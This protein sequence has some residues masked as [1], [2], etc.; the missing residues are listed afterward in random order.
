MTS[1]DEY[2]FVQIQSFFSNSSE[3]VILGE[4]GPG[5]FRFLGPA[6]GVVPISP[7]GIRD[8]GT[9]P[10]SMLSDALLS[11]NY[12]FDHQG[13]ISN[14]SC[15]Y[16]T[17]SPITFLAVPNDTFSVWVNASCNEVGLDDIGTNY[18]V[19]DTDR[20]LTLWACK[21]IPT[22]EQYPA[23]HIYLRGSGGVYEPEIGNITCTVSPIQ[24]AVFP[25]TYQSRTGI[26]STQKQI[27]AAAP[28]NSFSNLIEYAIWVFQDVLQQAQTVSVNLVAALVQDLG[29]QGGV[30]L[31]LQN[32]QYLRLYEAMIQGILVDEV[33]TASNSSP[34]LLM[35]VPQVTYMRFLY[36][37]MDP[38]ASCMRTM[39]GT[40]SAEVTGLVA[41]PVHIAFLI[42]MTILNLVSLIAV[43]I[44]IA[45]AKRGRHEFDPIDPRPLL[46]AEPSLNQGDDSGW[47]D[48]VLYRSR[49][50]RG[51]HI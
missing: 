18:T 24:P 28:A 26:F 39:N 10:P 13:L 43:L 6:R 11:Y 44:S 34:P 45:K 38:P 7:N 20:T 35:V 19:S 25:V 12:T 33:C 37:M 31:D 3:S 27:T 41:K 5:S 14:I 48:R 47:S 51:Y 46:L 29:V 15:I 49:E 50:V 32:E 8:L 1:F 40:F 42:P 16:D 21:S 2:L 4:L 22:G 36:S 17:Q 9:L 23:Y 30:P